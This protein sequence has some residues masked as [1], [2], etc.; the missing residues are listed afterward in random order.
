MTA[1]HTSGIYGN[2]EPYLAQQFNPAVGGQFNPGV[3]GPVGSGA[4]GTGYGSLGSG[5]VPYAAF[6]QQNPWAAP[7]L[8]QLNTPQQQVLHPVQSAV[9]AAQQIAA[10]QAAHAVQC[11][12][13]LQQI[14]QH[15]AAQQFAQP[16][17]GWQPQIGQGMGGVFAAGQIGQ[18]IPQSYG[19]GGQTAINP[20]PQQ[21]AMTQ[22]APYLAA[23][24]P[25]QFR[26]G[27]VH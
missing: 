13:A 11:A 22:L 2:Y 16:A 8:S 10:R 24:Q 21:Q 14:V 12:Q 20:G 5:A 4:V 19:W 7:Y 23:Q 15:L 27:W 1:F 18:A 25:E 26:Q 3:F 6:A 17:M 9:Q